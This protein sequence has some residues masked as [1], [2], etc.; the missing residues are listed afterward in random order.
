MEKNKPECV[1]LKK[2]TD[3]GYRKGK[4]GMGSYDSKKEGMITGSKATPG[5]HGSVQFG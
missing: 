3:E 1:E 4:K 2:K 5:R